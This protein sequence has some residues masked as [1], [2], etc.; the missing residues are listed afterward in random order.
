VSDEDERRDAGR[1]FDEGDD[2]AA[3]EP[4]VTPAPT[5]AGLGD[6]EIRALVARLARRHR[7]GGRVIERAAVLASGADSAAVLAWIQAHGGRA[8]ESAPPAARGLHAPRRAEGAP[9]P[10]RY[11]LPAGALR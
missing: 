10:P 8:E 7:S 9:P 11:V 6:D 2:A 5:V 3:E 1:A 4:D